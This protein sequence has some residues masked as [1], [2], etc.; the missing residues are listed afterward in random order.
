VGKPSLE[1]LRSGRVVEAKPH[2]GI[3]SRGGPARMTTEETP[4]R[5]SVVEQQVQRKAEGHAHAREG[6]GKGASNERA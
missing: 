6:G 4:R 2:G 5:G 1:G 3:G